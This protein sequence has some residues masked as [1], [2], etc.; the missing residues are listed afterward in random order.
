MMETLSS[1]FILPKT[2]QLDA[3]QQ[4]VINEILKFSA[5]NISAPKTA[6][7]ILNGDAGAGK[8]IVLA[9][10]FEKLQT[11][12]HQKNTPFTGFDNKLLV[13][14]NEMLKIYKELATQSDYLY[15]KDFMKPTPFIN[16]Y[17]KIQQ[18]ADIVM[19]DEGHLLLTKD[20]PFNNF[21]QQNQLTEI[22]QLAKIVIFVF[23]PQQVVKLKSYWQNDGLKNLLKDYPTKYYH[24]NQQYR[25]QN[26]DVTDWINAFTKGH[27]LEKPQINN[28]DL[29]FFADGLP[30]YQKIQEKNKAV[31][32]SRILATADFPFTVLD[33]KTW[34]V[35]AGQLKLPWDKINFTDRPWAERPETIDEVGSIYTIQ[36]F[37]LNYAGVILGPSVKY[38][39]KT[40]KIYI[41]S[42]L[43]EDH[44]AFK[45]RNDI[46]A[47]NQAKDT[48]VMNSVNILLK[49][50]KFGLYLY[51]SDPIL[52]KHLLA[53]N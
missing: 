45:K 8:S 15:K 41:D 24:L 28:F 38:D 26:K 16:H 5:Q 29:E 13:N 10:A 51:A 40:D 43:Y 3:S 36:G 49:R 35:T 31:G 25:V 4:K 53:L 46:P 39:E 2:A 44:E 21:K 11:L 52:R 33:D 20:D 48:I 7:F 1:S 6:I 27:L 47:L 19:I 14:H 37:D 18:Q 42:S 12:A 23:D 32:L 30:L 22:M 50:G 17:H 9:S 34:F